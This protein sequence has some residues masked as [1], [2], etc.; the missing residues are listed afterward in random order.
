MSFQLVVVLVV[1]AL[2]G[3]FFDGAVHALDLPV[4]PGMIGFGEPVID[5]VQRQTLSKG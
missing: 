1:V 4:G 2:D 3:G 5:A